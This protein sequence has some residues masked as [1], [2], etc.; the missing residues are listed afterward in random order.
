ML[1]LQERYPKLVANVEKYW[2]FEPR[3]PGAG[4]QGRRRNLTSTEPFTNA[5]YDAAQYIDGTDP[6]YTFINL[7]PGE[8]RDFPVLLHGNVATPGPVVPRHFLSVLSKGDTTFKNGSGRLELADH[9]FTDASALTARVM[10]NRVWDWHFGRPLVATPS[11]FGVQGEKPSNPTLLND[12][13]ARFIAHGWSLKW[14]NREM[15][16]SAA[17]QQSSKPREDGLKA[18][19]LN[20]MLWR[21]NPRRLDVESY[22]DT[23]LRSAGRLDDKMYGPSEDVEGATN[24]RRTVYGRVSRARMSTLLKYYDFPDPMQTS[25]GRDLTTTA[26]QQFFVMNSSFMHDEAAA[27]T[28]LVDTEPNETEKVTKLYRDVLS[29][30][31]SPKELDL[32]LSYLAG[33]T[34]D[35]Y[36]QIL[37]STNEEIFWP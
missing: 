7:K 3:K 17:Y 10:V 24:L 25:G 13:A 18:D 14:L 8:A 22:R 35:Q 28:K 27:L 20:T 33:G 32:A 36:A 16:L 29:R 11:D 37:L 12:L 19:I 23:L 6:Q 1:T 15:M 4:G 2:N 9:M 34:I 31:P 30:D 21:M 5:V 26:L